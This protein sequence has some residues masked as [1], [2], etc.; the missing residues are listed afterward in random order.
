MSP[1]LKQPSKVGVCDLMLPQLHVNAQWLCESEGHLW[2][3]SQ[4][5]IRSCNTDS[6][7]FRCKPST[8]PSSRPNSHILRSWLHPNN[9]DHTWTGQSPLSS[10]SKYLL[11]SSISLC[12]ISLI[13]FCLF[14][15]PICPAALPCQLSLQT[16]SFSPVRSQ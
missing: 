3:C 16:Q 6:L 9:T 12:L 13:K 8:K 15:H 10:F 4:S 1:S 11:V 5:Q 7:R 14:P 2:I